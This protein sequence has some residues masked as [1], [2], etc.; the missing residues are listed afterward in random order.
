M[1]VQKKEHFILHSGDCVGIV[2]CS[3]GIRSN[4][5]WQLEQLQGVLMQMGLTPILSPYL[6]RQGH[7]NSTGQQRAEAF[8]DCYRDNNIA[9]VFDISGGDLAN[10]IL[11]YL[12][13]EQI[14]QNPKLIF[15][16]SDLTVLLNAIYKKTEQKCYLYQLRN[17]VSDRGTMQHRWFVNSLLQ[18][19]E[20]LYQVHWHWLQNISMEGIVVG[21][22]LRCL[23]KLAGTE[24]FPNMENKLLFLESRSG[25]LEFIISC[26]TQL[27]QMGIFKQIKGLL[28]G[29]FSQLD[30]E[31][32]QATLDRE[33]LRILNNRLLP[34]AR[35]MEIGHGGD[36]KCLIIGKYY[37]IK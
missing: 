2:G 8:M 6:F 13:Y 12:D 16:Y 26:L 11:E 21:G 19:R 20:D 18:G 27:K 23:L 9:A 5:R 17:L 25:T 36:S 28:L 37:K 15:G 34:V 22:N 24:Y 35:T 30:E 10:E 1:A 7:E 31:R 4:A 3:N 32:G 33:V 14:Q 29:T